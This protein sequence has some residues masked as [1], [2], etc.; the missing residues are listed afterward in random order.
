MVTVHLSFT[1]CLFLN[2]LV[3]V[4][5]LRIHFIQLHLYERVT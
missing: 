4:V 5:Y 2:Y 1:T 3:L